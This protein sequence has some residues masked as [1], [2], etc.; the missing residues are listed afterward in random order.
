MLHSWRGLVCFCFCVLHTVFA[1][2]INVQHTQQKDT[3]P[4][5][6][7]KCTTQLGHLPKVAVTDLTVF[8]GGSPRGTIN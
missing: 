6:P 1:H 8:S 2:A 4:H 3:T 5:T 7:S